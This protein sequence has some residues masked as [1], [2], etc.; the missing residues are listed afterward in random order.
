M[1]NSLLKFKVHINICTTVRGRGR[2]GEGGKGWGLKPGLF[3][4]KERK[5]RRE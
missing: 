5:G 1:S 3:E 2:G 4:D